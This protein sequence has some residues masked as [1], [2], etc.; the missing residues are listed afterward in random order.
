M[1]TAVGRDEAERLAGELAVLAEPHRLLVLSELQAGPR[2]AGALA[3]SIGMAPSLASHHLA[4]L[5]RA[6]LVSRW[7]EGS[8][9]F[10]T[11][12]RKRVVELNQALA[13]LARSPTVRGNNRGSQADV[14]VEPE[15]Q[16]G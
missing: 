15:A 5:L 3:K 2:S 14:E 11:L 12:N 13:R 9:V 1:P 8:F 6:D 4:V 7:R 16:F 10:Y